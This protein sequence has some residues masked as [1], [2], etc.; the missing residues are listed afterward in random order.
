MKIM[1]CNDFAKYEQRFVFFI[2]V[3]G[4][5]KKVENSTKSEE[6]K[7]IID[8]LKQDFIR[9]NKRHNLEYQ[10][11]QISDCIIISFKNQPSENFKLLSIILIIEYLQANAF[12]KYGL[13]FRGAGTY[14]NLIHNDE[15]LF[16]TA[17]QEVYK[18]ETKYAIYP[19]IIIEK[20][21]LDKLFITEKE[22]C[23]EYLKDDEL[24]YYIDFLGNENNSDDSIEE[25]EKFYNKAKEII[26]RG[27]NE[28]KDKDV[29]RKYEWLKEKYN[30]A[31]HKFYKENNKNIEEIVMNLNKTEKNLLEYMK[32][33]II[34][35][36]LTNQE[37]F[38]NFEYDITL[39]KKG[40]DLEEFQKYYNYSIENIHLA[41]DN[42]E[43]QNYILKKG[44]CKT[45][46]N[47]FLK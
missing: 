41:L 37:M 45:Y 1:C 8:C 44:I 3:L 5:S 30:K 29:S 40:N 38:F 36:N 2:D 14:G 18:L 46:G 32:K 16:G 27:L 21:I 39:N 13:L 12:V 47:I 17:Y 35:A 22:Y 10:I 31:I 34:N 9:E 26:K 15:Y 33:A 23:L 43:K 11:T 25:K 4:F 7:N 20:E 42:L 24:F 28:S 6:I 19:R